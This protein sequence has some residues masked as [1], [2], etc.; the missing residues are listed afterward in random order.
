MRL[1]PGLR[2]RPR[3]DAY[4]AL[5]DSLAGFKGPLRG[6]EGEGEGREGEGRGGEGKGRRREGGRGR[7]GEGRLTVTR[8]WNRAADWYKAFP[9]VIVVS[10]FLYYLCRR[11]ASESI[12]SR[13]VSVCP[14]H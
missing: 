14:L 2:P 8:S 13:C 5:P 3:W 9:D 11:L 12:A 4:S 7:E 6:G 10:M 1:R